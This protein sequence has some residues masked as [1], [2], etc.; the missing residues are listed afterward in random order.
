MKPPQIRRTRPSWPFSK[1][2]S[3]RSEQ[4]HCGIVRAASVSTLKFVPDADPVSRCKSEN[5]DENHARRIRCGR[6]G[7]L[8]ASGR[9]SSSAPP[10]RPLWR[11]EKLLPSGWLGS[12]T[13]ELRD[14]TIVCLPCCAPCHFRFQPAPARAGRVGSAPMTVAAPRFLWRPDSGHSF[15]VRRMAASVESGIEDWRQTGPV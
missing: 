9:P 6:V 14:V 13:V 7:C 8:R 11:R 2:F 5:H 12:R 15:T 1:P 3:P 10:R 4:C